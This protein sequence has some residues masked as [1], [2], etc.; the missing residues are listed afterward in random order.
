MK[1]ERYK[2]PNGLTVL[3]YVDRTVPLVTYH[4]WFKVGSRDEQPGYTGIAHLFEHMMFKGA[5]RYGPKEFDKV[6][7]SNGG[8]NNAFTSHDYTGYFETLPSD[9]L[10]LM[11]DLESD[12]MENLQI[13]EANLKSEREVVKEERRYRVENDVTGRLFEETYATVFKVH[14]YRWPVIGWMEDLDRIT[15]EKCLEFYK[16]YYAPNNAVVVIAGDFDKSN[17]KKLIEKYY[18][19]MK[20]QPIPSRAVAAEPKQ[21]AAREHVFERDVQS[22]YMTV[23]FQNAQAGQPDYYALDVLALILGEGPSSRLY[24]RLVYDTQLASSVGVSNSASKDPGLFSV[25]VALKPGVSQK[26]VERIVYDEIRHARTSLYSEFEIQKAKNAIMT[27]N[28]GMLK[29]VYGKA[30]SLAFNEVVMGSYEY[31]FKDLERYNKVTA[32]QIQR[33]ATAVLDN[34]RRNLIVQKAKVTR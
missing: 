33:A 28:V 13:S 21:E 5:K 4:T 26:R 3:M 29:T 16:T 11:I 6:I 20:S 9:K 23:A 32:A 27:M 14:P 30:Q 24:K 22:D 31:L 8:T 10:E 1:V 2:L 7:Q 15:V 12:R 25:T 18:G 34:S 17:A 19:H